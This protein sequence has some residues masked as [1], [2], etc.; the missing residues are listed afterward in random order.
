MAYE[1]TEHNLAALEPLFKPW[2]EPS[3]YRLP[4]PKSG[5]AALIQP[6]RRPSKV[7]LVRGIRAEVDRWR[8]GGYAGVSA[9]SRHLLEY[10]FNTEH[11]V[12]DA[13]D[14]S[15][16]FRYHWAQREAIETI[17]Y[18]YELRPIRNVAELMFEFGD[19]A[20]GDLALGIDPKEDQ[21]AKYCAKIATGGGKTKV[22]SLAIVWSYFHSL[23]EPDSPLARHFVIIAP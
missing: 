8:R 16:P 17:I 11:Q 22:M 14:N 1:V 13:D 9:T 3:R 15:I 2:E 19:E 6:G 23:Y 10:W 21:W 7:P 18:L 5:E 12:I 20:L 4:N